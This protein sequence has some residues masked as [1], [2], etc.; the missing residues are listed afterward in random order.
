MSLPLSVIVTAYN[1]REYLADALESLRRQDASR[2]DFEV[3][4]VKNFEDSYLDGIIEDMG[5]LSLYCDSPYLP[6][7]TSDAIRMARGRVISFLDDDDIFEREKISDVIKVFDSNRDI[8]YYHHSA[9]FMDEKG[10]P[11]KTPYAFNFNMKKGQMGIIT[12][13]NVRKSIN[14]LIYL[15]HDF[16]RSCIAVRREILT[17]RMEYATRIQSAHD[18]F[19]FYSAAMSGKSIFIDNRKLTRYRLNRQSVS[20]SPA[21]RFTQRQIRTYE[22]MHKMAVESGETEIANL[23]ERQI[24]FFKVISAVHDPLGSRK[25]VLKSTISFIA[26]DNAYSHL[27]NSFA[28]LLSFTYLFSPGL[29]KKL[30]SKLTSPQTG[31]QR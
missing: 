30:Y 8:G 20:L 12:H 7:F 28:G 31:L 26:H 3:I 16:N 21:Y 27:A 19:I 14:R 24:L 29:S 15:R 22:L 11:V 5:A 6:S 2:D 13:E 10:R 17:E 1:R 25:N 18:S 4:V 9:S 23:L